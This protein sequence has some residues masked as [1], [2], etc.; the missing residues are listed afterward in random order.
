M[1]EFTAEGYQ[2]WS[3]WEFE[4]PRPA[5]FTG[6]GAVFGGPQVVYHYPGPELTLKYDA[7]DTLS[8]FPTEEKPKE[9]TMQKFLERL[10]ARNKLTEEDVAVL[11]E[12]MEHSDW[13]ERY[14]LY[15]LV[16][17]VAANDP[18]QPT[19]GPGSLGYEERTG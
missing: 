11:Q 10:I 3:R 5:Y 13:K 18:E 6:G 14:L 4:P 2:P 19:F 12:I 8:W 16:D 7:A 1:S 17:E 9:G 15:L